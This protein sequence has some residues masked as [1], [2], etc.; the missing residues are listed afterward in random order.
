MLVPSSS[1]TAALDSAITVA[2][3]VVAA[4]IG[5]ELCHLPSLFAF[6][7]KALLS[8]RAGAMQISL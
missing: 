2:A 6:I 7:Q 5:N 1:F 8:V 3:M 4:V